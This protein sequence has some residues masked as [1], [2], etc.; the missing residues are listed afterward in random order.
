MSVTNLDQWRRMSQLLDALLD[1]DDAQRPE[2]LARIHSRDPAI[3]ADLQ[4]LLA[5]QAD[6]DTARFLEDSPLAHMSDE[7]LTGKVVGNY[8]LE[9]L[10]G[11]GGM[12]SVWLARRSDG[13][14]E[15]RAAVKF[16]NLAL[17]T[18]LGRA[19]FQ[20]EGQILARLSHPRIAQLID[21]GTDSGQPYLTIEYVPGQPIDQWCERL[22]LTI[23]QRIELFQ[24]VLTAV[25]YA[26]SQM[27]LHRDL[28]PANILVNK[29]GSVKLLD[30][31]I[32][33]LLE[34]PGSLTATDEPVA[35]AQAFTPDF[36][37]PE[38][39][40]GE[41]PSMA[42]DVY[43]LGMLLYLLLAGRQ[44]LPVAS[45]RAERIK[46]ALDGTLPLASAYAQESLKRTLRGDLDA[47]LSK[48]LR[49]DPRERYSTVSA[50][51]EDLER[52][53]H[54]RPV[55]ARRGAFLYRVR[56]FVLRHPLGV[57][58]TAIALACLGI[59]VSL[60]LRQAQI[61]SVERNR[62]TELLARSEA[63]TNFTG[64]IIADALSSSKPVSVSEML[65]R[66]ADLAVADASG[67]PESR[68]S[69]L[70][71]LSSQY[72]TLEDF[73]NSAR[74]QARALQL[75]QESADLDL[76]ATIACQHA[77][78]IAALGEIPA[79]D[80]AIEAVLGA[81]DAS[82]P[83]MAPCLLGRAEIDMEKS[84]SA[85]ALRHA[86]EALARARAHPG[87]SPETEAKYLNIVGIT[88]ASA[89][90]Y[91][92][93]I[94]WYDQALQRLGNGSRGAS[95]QAIISRHNKAGALRQAGAPHLALALI[96]ET[97]RMS[98]T[99]TSQQPP[100]YLF[101][102]RAGALE[103]MGRYAEARLACEVAYDRAATSQRYYSRIPPLSVMRLASIERHQ[104]SP[105][106]VEME[107]QRLSELRGGQSI[108]AS[109]AARLIRASVL[110]STGQFARARE[111]LDAVR[112]SEPSVPTSNALQLEY[113]RLENDLHNS[114]SAIV[115][116]TRALAI[117]RQLQGEL[118]FSNHAGLAW[119]ELGR[120]HAQLGDTSRAQAAYVAAASHL[121]QTVD[122]A[123]PALRQ[124]RRQLS[125]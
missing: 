110:R 58:G 36:A 96:D 85:A 102:N 82:S 45:E 17:F 98:E 18:V 95:T 123:H 24:D 78:S 53:L 72:E 28:K 104:R 70:A 76:R 112:A 38:Q 7:M 26:H 106:R 83:S 97:L 57:S 124:A 71:M 35:T 68:A 65:S 61:A 109:S 75:L 103:A 66:S 23:R 30:F 29:D 63:V 12:G 67:T 32:A 50:F 93:A 80:R 99:E 119:L 90:Q 2:Y 94:P 16:L 42:T 34:E 9:S 47:I 22:Q 108:N 105:R 88:Y 81:L 44:P 49:R 48:A 92:A 54:R 4:R 10:I 118:P 64:V 69:V 19:R 55:E 120:A 86:H 51:K 37:A 15:G 41:I 20:R 52:Y 8:T 21:A 114:D 33:K 13:R 84:D 74:L 1:T 89:D 11:S 77:T 25:V 43:Q 121:E 62:A 111:V 60:A 100:A 40:L 39:L 101:L 6:I 5:R 31:G 116:A 107:F 113:A 3:A 73:E 122:A 59:T 79:A 87:L 27:V 125:Q 56:K 117:A 91:A 115:A 46:V 14:Y